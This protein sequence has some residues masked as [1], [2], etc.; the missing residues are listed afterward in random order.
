MMTD[1]KIT[2]TY[3]P[4]LHKTICQRAVHNKI[5]IGTAQCH[6]HDYDFENKLTGQHYAYTRSMIKEMCQLRDEYKIQLKAL[7][8]L[9]NIYEQSPN[10]D[11]YNS[12][13]CYYLRRQMQV[14]QRDIDEMKELISATRGDLRTTIAEKD[15]LYAKLR[16]ARSSSNS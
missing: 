11:I 1:S 12:E 8:H 5:Y 3:D 14:V 9:Y 7:K 10:I 4:E 16:S 15:K 6:P 13:E 2:F